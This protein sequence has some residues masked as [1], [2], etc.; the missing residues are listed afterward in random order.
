M[1]LNENQIITIIAHNINIEKS[2][3]RKIIYKLYSNKNYP[4]PP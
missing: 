4:D 1:L 3:L 2:L